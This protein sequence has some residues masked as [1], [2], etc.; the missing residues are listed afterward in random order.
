MRCTSRRRDLTAF[1]S[2]DDGNSWQGGLLLEGRQGR[3]C[4]YSDICPFADGTIGVLYDYGRADP[5]EILL[6]RIT[7]AD[8]LVGHLGR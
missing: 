3:D 7:E 1:L 8:V 5:G 2:D 6:A 4:S